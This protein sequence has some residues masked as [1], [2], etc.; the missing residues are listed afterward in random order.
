MINEK[1]ILNN[2][3]FKGFALFLFIYFENKTR[4]ITTPL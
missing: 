1:Q 2:P 4:A 3:Y